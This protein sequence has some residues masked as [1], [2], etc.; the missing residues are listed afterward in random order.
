MR[1]LHPRA[2]VVR[3]VIFYFNTCLYLLSE[4]ITDKVEISDKVKKQAGAV[5]GQAQLKLAEI[6]EDNFS[7]SRMSE[8]ESEQK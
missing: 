5:L 7:T 4:R 8:D 2:P 6:D 1:K 3:L